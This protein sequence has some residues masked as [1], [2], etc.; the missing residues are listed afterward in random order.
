MNRSPALIET[1][2]MRGGVAP[3]WGHH[4]ARVVRSCRALGV[5]LPAALPAP[6]EGPDRIIRMVVSAGGV[7]VAERPVGFTEPVRL[8]VSSVRHAPYPHKT[9]DRELF[10][11]SRAE[12]EAAGADDGVLLVAAGWV[13]ETAIWGLY[14]WEAGRL[15]APPLDFGILRSVARERL[16]EII[17]IEERRCS[18]AELRGHPL[19]VANAA[20]GVVEVAEFD[21]NASP[22]DPRSD[23]LVRAFWP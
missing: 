10:D 20:R 21:G 2:R 4:V 9:T 15:C 7:D 1:V 22:R 12:A 3:L 17:R 13:A 5:P 18:P 14:W 11:R 16:N 6:A 19:L 23:E 8:A